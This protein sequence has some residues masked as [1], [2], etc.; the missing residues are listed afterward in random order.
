[1]QP[2]LREKI[3]EEA[4]GILY[5]HGVKRIT[6]R[7]LADALGYSPATLYLYFRSKRELIREISLQGF[8]RLERVVEMSANVAD[9]LDAVADS[10]HRYIDFG[11]ENGELYRL[12]FQDLPLESYS[13]RE[14]AHF[15]L[16]WAFGR[17]LHVRALEDADAAEGDPDT[18]TSTTWATMH[19]FVQLALS[20][21]LPH[22]TAVRSER[23]GALRDAV[24]GSRML[25]LR[26]V[27]GRDG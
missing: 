15:E 22:P 10:M 26:C 27:S 9:P 8:E 13:S 2:D 20:Q 5:R 21:R 6:M 4:I 18:E 3:L 17:S 25:G 24:I 19:G 12:M 23:L 16:L 1:M 7:A 11:L 14:L